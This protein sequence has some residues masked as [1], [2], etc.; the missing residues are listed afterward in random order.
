M[1]SAIRAFYI[2]RSWELNPQGSH[3]RAI[4]V[5]G[6]RG[7]WSERL[8]RRVSAEKHPVRGT[9]SSPFCNS[10]PSRGL[11]DGFFVSKKHSPTYGLRRRFRNCRFI[12]KAHSVS[13]THVSKSETKLHLSLD[14]TRSRSVSHLPFYRETLLVSVDPHILNA[15]KK[16]AFAPLSFALSTLCETETCS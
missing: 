12:T 1:A 2:R 3:E 15:Y 9:K 10:L 8:L 13:R 11:Q 6:I 7:C 5:F 4:F 16:G 14:F